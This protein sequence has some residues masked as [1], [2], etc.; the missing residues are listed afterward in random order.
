MIRSHLR[1][2]GVHHQGESTDTGPEVLK[3][4]LLLSAAFSSNRMDHNVR[5]SFPT[6]AYS[7]VCAT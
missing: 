6:P 1:A 7:G 5:P 3:V 2:D 4:E